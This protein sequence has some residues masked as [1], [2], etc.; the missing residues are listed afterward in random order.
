MHAPNDRDVA[1]KEDSGRNKPLFRTVSGVQGCH[2]ND[3]SRDLSL[4]HES[5]TEFKPTFDR[6]RVVAKLFQAVL[7]GIARM[8]CEAN[9]LTRQ[10]VDTLIFV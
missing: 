5:T 8:T 4:S 2:T 3:L 7:D 10:G 6:V 9:V 1:A